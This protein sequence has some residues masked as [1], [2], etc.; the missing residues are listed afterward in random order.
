M[1]ADMNGWDF[2]ERCV[3][4]VS[5]RDIGGSRINFPISEMG[6]GICVTSL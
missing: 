6:L 5:F 3:K 1:K 4:I 2:A